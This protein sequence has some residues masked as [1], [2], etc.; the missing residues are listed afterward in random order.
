MSITHGS[1]YTRVSKPP[2]LL[3]SGVEESTRCI[4]GGGR[5][6]Y[7]LTLSITHLCRSIGTLPP[8]RST[9]I[10][11]AQHFLWTMANGT[12]LPRVFTTNQK[13]YSESPAPNIAVHAISNCYV[14]PSPLG[15][16]GVHEPSGLSIAFFGD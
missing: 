14:S 8:L 7:S 16:R 6:F 1:V 15:L 9:F 2:A 3:D 10:P 11:R 13:K 5:R 4:R 12:M